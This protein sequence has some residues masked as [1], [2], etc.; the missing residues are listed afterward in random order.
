MTIFT[1]D[2][3]AQRIYSGNAGMAM[4]GGMGMPMMGNPMMGPMGHGGGF[5]TNLQ[6]GG[7]GMYGEQAAAMMGS[8]GRGAMAMGR[9]GVELGAGVMGGMAGTGMAGMM[10][11]GAMSGIGI[12]A[13]VMGGMMAS[14]PIMA[15]GAAASYYGN[16]FTGG[17]NDQ[18]ALNA[19]MRANFNQFGGGGPMG[20][21]FGQAQMG[22]VGSMISSELRR[23][24]FSNAQEMNQLI[25]GGAESG[26]MTGVRDVQSFTQNFRRMLDTLRSVQRE[27]GG[28]LTDALQFVRTSQQA[29]IFQSADRVNFAAEVRNAE[30]VTGMDRTQLTALAATG[31]ATSRAFGGVGR[32]G[33][34]G[35]LR[36]AS[37]LGAAMSSG[38]INAEMLSEAT[39][40]L[41]GAEA[42]GAF[43]QNMMERSGR[44]SRTGAG[45]W[46][47]FAMSNASGTGI[48][49][50]MMDRFATG[51]VSSGDIMR[52]AHE[53]VGG[54][55]RARALNSEGRLRGEV[56][57]EGG[58]AVQLG[59]FR[60]RLGGA[61]A[62]LGSDRASLFMQ[63]RMGMSHAESN[64]MMSL[65]RNQS[66]IAERESFD[67]M[68]SEREA[69]FNR[70][71]SENRGVGAFMTRFEHGLNEA[72]GGPEVREAARRFV[73]RISSAAERISDAVVGRTTGSTMS[74]GDRAAINR[75][76]IG[77][78]TAA[79]IE[80]L[81]LSAGTPGAGSLTSENLFRRSMAG[82]VLG[83][84]GMHGGESIGERMEA[85]GV[86]GLRGADAGGN[87][88]DF[89]SRAADAARGVVS[90]DL[91]GEVAANVGDEA[92]FTRR[93]LDAR[94][95]AGPAGSDF[96]RLMG[97]DI[98]A[99]NAS[100][101]LLGMP[102][103][104]LMPGRGSL[105]G[106]GG[107]GWRDVAG[108]MARGAMAG[109]AAGL[110]HGGLAGGFAGAVGGGLDSITA[111]GADPS[112]GAAARIA[113][114]DA[115]NARD[116]ELA[117]EL[118]NMGGVGDDMIRQLTAE[119]SGTSGDPRAAAALRMINRSRGGAT[120][121]GVTA[122]T[123]TDSFRRRISRLSTM[124]DDATGRE[125]ILASMEREVARMAPGSPEEASAR[126]T[127]DHLRSTLEASGGTLDADTMAMAIDP[128]RAEETRD[129]LNRL[130]A[131]A[132]GF[133]RGLEGVEGAGD[134]AGRF[135]AAGEAFR[136]GDVDAANREMR[137][138]V[139]DLT[140]LDPDSE[141]Y[142][143][144]A[145]TLSGTAEG[146]AIL[147]AASGDRTS[148]RR[149]SGARGRA[150]VGSEAM[151]ILTGGMGVE[152]MNIEVGP[153]GRRRRLGS[154]S[155][156]W[157]RL[158]RG[159]EGAADI[160]RQLTT[161]LEG[162]GASDA[163]GLTSEF[164]RMSEGGITTDEAARMR[165]LT[166]ADE[167]LNTAAR[168]ATDA[169]MRAANPLDAA[170]NDLLTEIRNF[171]RTTATGA[172]TRDSVP[173]AE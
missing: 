157:E 77:R 135:T 140:A 93:I 155:S 32:S 27:L 137:G 154:A 68:G 146:R 124:S 134:L 87:A 39:G 128:R 69:D 67:A 150:A 85:L 73:T 99:T 5:I 26:M 20:R 139:A 141:E 118:G 72:L 167:G 136:S 161:E 148:N 60:E 131:N 103:T 153:E 15:A 49:R 123:S 169:A 115:A 89:M 55:G 46:S 166:A 35:A 7:A 22:Q 172:S 145:A 156:I 92:A 100:M 6:R 109:G 149:L 170:R 38:S 143:A 158:T 159:G 17:M 78:G 173:Q 82:D 133:A 91:R 59:L 95:A 48:D 14:A 34:Y 97:G 74:E 79:D 160:E 37:T 53:N 36:G 2:M 116:R 62:D 1:S 114:G 66:R 76:S 90:E 129:E 12:G 31:A 94:T 50:E 47:L 83:M 86:R 102:E 125:D 96:Y 40:G 43:T 13:G 98:H 19:T 75:V 42:I 54:M 147:R 120:A 132:R 142:R 30:A 138:A 71:M 18:A 112:A 24:P 104:G 162:M 108:G 164:R 127:I 64:V 101:S 23:N 119:A 33:A 10:G 57:A 21:G 9:L 107:M 113:R 45:R 122:Y 61:G 25:A 41:T 165:E 163:A 151:D 4:A 44:F 84:M 106:L 58:L 117:G 8:A 144:R 65:M 105:S 88:R 121:E 16:Q 171:T 152:G 70:E 130:S 168:E 63:R 28:T 110:L 51:D 29:G 81:R 56:M 111:L 52:R 80:L 3:I 126:N 11:Y